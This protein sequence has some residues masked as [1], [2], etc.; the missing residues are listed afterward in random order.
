M[1]SL[2]SAAIPAAPIYAAVVTAAAA[3]TVQGYLN[4]S[5]IRQAKAERMLTSAQKFLAALERHRYDYAMQRDLLALFEAKIK[6]APVDLDAV[7]PPGHNFYWQMPVVVRAEDRIYD[8]RAEVYGRLAELDQALLSIE[9]H[10]TPATWEAAD[11][12]VL[13]AR[14]LKS[15]PETAAAAERAIANVRERNQKIKAAFVQAVLE[16]VRT[17]E[18][19]LRFPQRHKADGLRETTIER[20]RR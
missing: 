13:L 9:M 3:L 19:V 5:K 2:A 10:F 18:R 8:H 20:L 16:D 15:S 12:L 1:I 14:A 6:A 4:V 11:D 7:D 17:A